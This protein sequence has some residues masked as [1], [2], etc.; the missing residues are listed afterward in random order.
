MNSEVPAVAPTE[1]SLKG[2][3]ISLSVSKAL[4]LP[5]HKIIIIPLYQIV[6]V[7]F[8]LLEGPGLVLRLYCFRKSHEK[9]KSQSTH[10]V[11]N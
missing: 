2:S 5:L 11:Y 1:A 7:T 9:R 10:C 4:R 6:L 3:D 8:S